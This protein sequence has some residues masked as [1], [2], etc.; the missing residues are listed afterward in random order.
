[1]KK[2]TTLIFIIFNT[3]LYSQGIY[4]SEP[5][6]CHIDYVGT[7]GQGPIAYNW[8]HANDLVVYQYYAKLTYPDGT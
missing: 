1:M 4:F 6:S 2:W 7:S 5:T 3:L 8:Y